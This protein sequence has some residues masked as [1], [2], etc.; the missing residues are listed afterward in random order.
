M[1]NELLHELAPLLAEEGI[2]ADNIDVTDLDTLQRA[3][4]R[5]V[6]RH[7]MAMFTPVGQARE[8]AAVTM[9]LTAEA[10]A[11]GSTRLAASILDQAQP[12]S[13]DG[14]SAT[15]SACVG[16]A[17]SLL[18]QWLSGNDTKAPAGLA[19][20]AQLPAGH[21]AGER[22]ATDILTLARKGRAFAAPDAL[23]ARQGGRHVL[24]GSA[25]VLAATGEGPAR[26]GPVTLPA[27]KLIMDSVPGEPVAWATVDPVPGSGRVWAA[28]SRLHPQTGLVPIQ[29][30]GLHGDTRRPWDDGTSS[31]RKTRARRTG[32]MPV[33][34]WN[35]NGSA[36]CRPPAGTTPNTVTSG[37]RSPWNGPAWPRRRTHR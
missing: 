15:V 27:G 23:I 29:L 6:E 22:A 4:N 7:N 3:L 13:P 31:A 32:W 10:I 28:L 37:H 30:D 24:Y 36:G 34:C 25:L 19:K 1:A 14:S 9:R 11:D 20:L 33:P 5:A 16:L 12:E 8:L 2:D 35:P 26:L 18:D 21:W 17:L